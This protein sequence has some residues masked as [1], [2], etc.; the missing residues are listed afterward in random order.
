MSPAVFDA[1]ALPGGTMRHTRDRVERL[2]PWLAYGLFFVLGTV[3]LAL[4]DAVSLVG[5]LALAV[6]PAGVHWWRGTRWQSERRRRLTAKQCV[7][8][9]YDLHGNE[10]GICPECG[11]PAEPAW[12]RFRRERRA[13]DAASPPPPP[14]GGWASLKESIGSWFRRGERGDGEPGA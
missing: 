2:T 10:S 11:M 8:C 7:H 14:Q 6:I 1:E 9:G 12:L 4:I 5:L 13:A 3:L